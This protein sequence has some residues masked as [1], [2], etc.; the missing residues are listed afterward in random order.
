MHGGLSTGPKKKH[1]GSPAI[2]RKPLDW[3]KPGAAELQEGDYLLD[4]KRLAQAVDL[5]IRLKR[6]ARAAAL[7]NSC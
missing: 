3:C 2:V 5:M 7:S 4:I 6:R 1:N